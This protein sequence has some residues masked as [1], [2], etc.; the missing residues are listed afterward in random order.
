MA[1]SRVK[2]RP[3]GR[4][5]MQIYLGLK[6]GKRHYKTVYGASPKEVQNKADDVR[7]ALKKGLNI[8]AERDTFEVWSQRF[9]KM[10]KGSISN[11]RYQ[12][13]VYA[14]EKLEPISKLQISKIMPIDIQEVIDDLA[15]FNP[16]TGK[17]TAKKTLMDV[18]SAASQ[19]FDLAIRNRVLVFNPAKCVDLPEGKTQIKRRALTDEEQKWI[20]ETPHRAQIGAMI[21]MYAGLRRGELIPLT[22]GDIDLKNKTISVTKSVEMVNGQSRQKSGGKTEYSVRVI[23]IPKRLVEYLQPKERAKT[24][25]VCPSSH[26]TM[27]SVSAWRRL[28]ESYLALLNIKYGDFTN[29]CKVTKNKWPKSVHDP[30]EIPFVIPKIT[31]HWLRHTFATLLYMSGVDVLTAKEQLGH[32]DIKTTLEIYTHLDQKFKR[33]SMNKLDNYLNNASHMQVKGSEKT[34]LRLVK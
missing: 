20:E 6:E 30:H 1:K 26:G 33:R 32:S 5:A 16:Y 24:E 14:F 3:D 4:Y 29:Y 13:Y 18:K 23:D 28:W 12:I 19:V 9:L 25:L 7:A 15:K 27:L 17:P 22:W 31:A 34:S 8:S 11:G 2:K 10:K 21:M